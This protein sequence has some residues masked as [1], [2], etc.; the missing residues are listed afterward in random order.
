MIDI[1]SEEQK[2]NGSLKAANEQLS[3]TL[4]SLT[5]L[6]NSGQYRMLKGQIDSKNGL[7]ETVMERK[8]GVLAYLQAFANVNKAADDE[9]KKLPKPKDEL[10]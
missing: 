6:W 5:N 8:D 1:D 9:S 3:I 4:L 7:I 10:I 2:L